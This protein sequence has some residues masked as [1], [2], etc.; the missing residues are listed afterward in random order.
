[1]ITLLPCVITVLYS[2]WKGDTN[3]IML[4]REQTKLDIM[5]RQQ[6]NEQE[7]LTTILYEAVELWKPGGVQSS[8]LAHRQQQNNC[9]RT[10]AVGGYVFILLQKDFLTW[11][12]AFSCI[13][14]L[15]N[16]RL[17]S[18]RLPSRTLGVVEYDRG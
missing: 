3:Q 10:E 5:R 4:K 8:L 15:R 13:C 16:A 2:N 1:M 17:A 11:S 6:Q 9:Q 18:G 14:G 12:M 7:L